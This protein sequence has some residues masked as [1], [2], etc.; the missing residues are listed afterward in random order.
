MSERKITRVRVAEFSG[1]RTLESVPKKLAEIPAWANGLLGGVPEAYRQE[2]VFELEAN[3]YEDPE[4]SLDIYYDVPESDEEMRV[5]LEKEAA[6]K[7]ARKIKKAQEREAYERAV[8]EHL[9]Q[10]FGDGA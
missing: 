3:G 1:Y 8:Y 10:K 4:I 9:K 7:A 6:A 5:R 2:V